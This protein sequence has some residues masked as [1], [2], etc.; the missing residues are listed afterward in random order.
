MT[1]FLSKTRLLAAS[2]ATLFAT[3]SWAALPTGTLQY[4]TPTGTV[5]ANEQIDVWVRFTLDANSAPLNFSTDAQTGVVTGFAAADLPT[6]GTYFDA[7]LGQTVT[8]DFAQIT[9][10]GLNTVFYCTDTFT[11]ACNGNTTNYTFN[12]FTASQPGMPSINFAT[13]FNLAPGQSTDYVF[14]QFTPAAGGAAAGT[15]KLYNTGLFLYF[16][17]VDADG[18]SL[19]YADYFGSTGPNTLL[20]QTCPGGNSD[21][22]AFIRTVTAVPEPST[23]GLMAL[24]LAGVG[25]VKRRRDRKTQG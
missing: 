10:A 15:Y 18:H 22:C 5:G 7:A 4:I 21:S 16:T 6:Q 23:Y 1:T 8:A 11:G 13:S 12:F 24:G 9:G 3:A 14:G 19:Y 25:L 2:A 20:G 17:G